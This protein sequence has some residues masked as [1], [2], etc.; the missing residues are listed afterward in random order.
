MFSAGD[1]SLF[2]E[3]GEW[4][5]IGFPSQRNSMYYLCCSKPISDITFYFIIRRKPLHF[6]FNLILPCMLVTATAVLV[7]YLPAE[8]GEKVM[9]NDVV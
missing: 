1:L 4:E 6:L 2:I 5:V 7:F 3:D 8:S 9:I